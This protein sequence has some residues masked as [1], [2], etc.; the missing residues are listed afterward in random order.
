VKWPNNAVPTRTTTA[1]KTDV[2]SFFT[3]DNGT[4]WYG[5]LALFNFT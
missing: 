2:W 5:A 1:N 3:T 4:S